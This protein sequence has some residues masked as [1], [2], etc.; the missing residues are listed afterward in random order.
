[1]I[2]QN[3]LP[4]EQAGVP[5][6]SQYD[7][8]SGMP[9][10]QGLQMPEPI[11]DPAQ[12]MPA[13]AQMPQQGRSKTG[14]NPVEFFKNFGRSVARAGSYS[15]GVEDFARDPRNAALL[16]RMPEGITEKLAA[17]TEDITDLDRNPAKAITYGAL[18]TTRLAQRYTDGLSAL[19][20]ES[21]ADAFTR[22]FFEKSQDLQRNFA[23]KA[24]T[25]AY[26]YALLSGRPPREAADASQKAYASASRNVEEIQ[27]ARFASDYE[28]MKSINNFV[29]GLNTVQANE[30]RGA[31]RQGQI[32]ADGERAPLSDRDKVELARRLQQI[33]SQ[34]DVAGGR[35]LIAEVE[36]LYGPKI[37]Q[38]VRQAVPKPALSNKDQETV[39][40]LKTLGLGKYARE[41]EDTGMLSDEGQAAYTKKRDA[42]MFR[43]ENL[44]TTT[45]QF[46][47]V[48]RYF[49]KEPGVFEALTAIQ[50]GNATADQTKLIADKIGELSAAKQRE[51]V[52]ET[53][54]V[55]TAEGQ[56]D[57]K[58]KPQ[59]A[60]AEAGAKAA[61]ELSTKP[62]IEA[63][64]TAAKTLAEAQATAQIQLPAAAAGGAAV[65]DQ[66]NS[67]LNN[68]AFKTGAVGFTGTIAQLI[69]NT[70]GGTRYSD[71]NA[72][73]QTLKS[74]QFIEGI[75]AARAA[76]GA[77]G[78]M[79]D[80][81]GRKIES[82]VAALD[83]RMSPREFERQMNIIRKTL[84]DGL[85]RTAAQ[86]GTAAPQL[87]AVRGSDN[88]R[89]P[90]GSFQR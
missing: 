50:T 43:E 32:A 24:A 25:N 49:G 48:A 79:S 19:N 17:K 29:T 67:L 38:Y 4:G 33:I 36:Q 57:L 75:R 86:A 37:A 45:K 15:A 64:V 12:Q 8:A 11:M 31:A 22:E 70:F 60:A 41:F 35:A 63:A 76:G 85:S 78:G 74:G 6:G 55:K 18:H 90:L 3:I 80:A 10:S 5:A 53:V 1:M 27:K 87:P 40:E 81:E 73:L 13:D 77:L 28:S 34:K 42:K 58:L 59:I 69:G 39:A 83:V 21:D 65:V 30:A 72:Q 54:A 23:E 56:V 20:P 26:R 88:P 82:A 89:P 9:A 71:F 51:K 84:Q 7:L 68:P 66:I 46:D 47:E 16:S 14:L 62:K 2:Q 44:K 61:V 52:G